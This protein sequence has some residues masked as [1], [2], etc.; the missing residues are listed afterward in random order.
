MNFGNSK[1]HCPAKVF[2]DLFDN[3]SK[4]LNDLSSPSRKDW[5]PTKFCLQLDAMDAEMADAFE[6]SNG[7]RSL[8]TRRLCRAQT[9]LIDGDEQENNSNPTIFDVSKAFCRPGVTPLRTYQAASCLKEGQLREIVQLLIFSH[10]EAAPTILRLLTIMDGLPGNW[11]LAMEFLERL[12]SDNCNLLPTRV[13]SLIANLGGR[14]SFSLCDWSPVIE[15]AF[16]DHETEARWA[17]TT[18]SEHRWKG[19]TESVLR[20]FEWEAE[21]PYALKPSVWREI[22]WASYAR[23][24]CMSGGGTDMST[25]SIASDVM[26]DGDSETKCFESLPSQFGDAAFHYVR[27]GGSLIRRRTTGTGKLMEVQDDTNP[28]SFSEDNDSREQPIVL[29]PS[30]RNAVREIASQLAY[31]VPFILEGPT[32]CGKTAI[33]SYLAQLTSYD[34]NRSSRG[35]HAP[36]VTFIQMDSAMMQGDGESFSSQIGTVVP[37]PEGGGFCWRPGA[38]GAAAERGDWIVLENISGSF[39]RM[40]SAV[41]I[42]RKLANAK[43]GD[44][45]EAPGRGEPITIG[46]GFRL[47]ATRTVSQGG[48]DESWD[49]PGG[50]ETWHRVTM[51]EISHDEK[52]QILSER[53][54]QISDCISRLVD[55]VEKV[56][57]YTE[58]LEGPLFRTPTLREAVRICRRLDSLKRNS[59]ALTIEN[60]FSETM[61]ALV[62]WCSSREHLDELSNIVA[63]GWSLSPTVGL[64][65]YAS[66][67]PRLDKTNGMVKIGR[68]SAQSSAAP[69]FEVSRLSL[70]GYT[71]RLLERTLRCLELG[72]PVLLSGE[73]GSGKT[74]IIQELASLMGKKLVV[75]NLSRQSELDDL[76]G[77]FRPVDA[78]AAVPLLAKRFES[79]FCQCM[80]RQKNA[81]FLDALQ[82]ASRST[83]RHSRALRLMEG[84]VTAI[85]KSSKQQSRTLRQ[86]WESII[87]VLRKLGISVN[88]NDTQMAPETSTTHN[89]GLREPLR[90]RP[91]ISYGMD[92][93]SSTEM[94]KPTRKIDFEFTDG[95][96][97]QAMRE[98]AWI[99]LDELNLGPPELLE[100]L[101]SILEVGRV[102]LAD[103][104]GSEISAQDGFALFGAMNPP[105]DTG[106]RPLPSVLR[107]RFTEIHVGDMLN[108]EDLMDLI[109]HKFIICSSENDSNRLSHAETKIAQDTTNFYLRSY[110]MAKEG[111]IEDSARRPVR[112]SLRSLSRMLDFAYG[113]MGF[114]KV[115]DQ[116]RRRA[117]CEGAI[118]AFGTQLPGK[119]RRQMYELVET[120]I[121]QES[122]R[123]F[124][125]RQLRDLLSVPRNSPVS[126][127][128][129][130]GFPVEWTSFKEGYRLKTEDRFIVTPAVEKTLT[131]VCRA[132]IV[133][134]PKLPILLQGPTAAGKTSLVSYLAEQ[135]GNKLVRINNHEHTELSEYIGR[136]VATEDGSLLFSEGPLVRAARRGYWVMLDE[137]NLA[138][139]DVLESLNRLLDD[140]R[141]VFIPETAEVVK[142]ASGF[143]L[144]ATQNPPGL[145]GGRKELSRAFRSR[146]IEVQVDELPD[147]DL[148]AILERRADIPASFARR[149]VAVMR[150]L[151][152]QRRAS[153]LFS[154]RE[155]YITARDLFRWAARGPRSRDE[156]AIHGFMLLAERAR[157]T[158]ERSVIRA[159]LCKEVGVSKE[160]LTD[161][162]LY[163]L[164]DANDD[165]D[166]ASKQCLDVSLQKLSLDRKSISCALDAR[167]IVLTPS[168]RRMLTLLIHSTANTEPVLLVGATGGGKTSCCAAIASA[169]SQQL[170]TVN[171]HRHT[172]ASDI[173]GGF[174]PVRE[175]ASSTSLFEWVD[176][177]LI[178]AMKEGSW[179]LIDEINMADDAV[180]ERLNP[181]LET[182][183]TILLSEKGANKLS[184]SPDIIIAAEKFR[185]LATMN[186]G[187]DFGKKELS[188]ALRNR[189]TEVWIPPPAC[190]DDYLPIIN[191]RLSCP[192]HR[193]EQWRLTS[194]LV[195]EIIEAS[196]HD[197]HEETGGLK[198]DYPS[199][200]VS[201]RDLSVWCEF[202][203][204]APNVCELDPLL[205]AVHGSRLVFLDGLSV[206]LASNHS[207]KL[208]SEIWNR[209]LDKMPPERRKLAEKARYDEEIRITV[210]HRDDSGQGERLK[211]DRFYI[212]TNKNGNHKLL[213]ECTS[214][215]SFKAP[216]TMRNSAR[217]ARAMC[218]GHRPVL[219]E[220]PPG[221]GKSSLIAALA[222]IS[223]F[224]YSRVNLS[225]GTEMSDLVGCDAPG[226]VQGKFVFRRGPL[227]EALT[228]GGWILLD[229]LNLAS[230]SVLEGLNSVLDHRKTLFVPELNE[231]FKAHPSFRVFGAQ[232][233][234]GDGGGRRGLPKSFLNR[235]TRVRVEAP[236]NEDF[237]LIISSTHPFLPSE[238]VSQLIECLHYLRESPRESVRAKEKFG[239]R[240]ALRWCDL[241]S[242]SYSRSKSSKTEHFSLA[243]L[244]ACF[245]VVI[246][247]G[248][249]ACERDAADICFERTFGQPCE[250]L[251]TTPSVRASHGDGFRIGFVQVKNLNKCRVEKDIG[252]TWVPLLTT[253]SSE[254]QALSFAVNACWPV[255]LFSPSS[256]TARF[257]SRRI[258]EQIA[259]LFGKKLCIFDGA[260]LADAEDFV[261]SYVQ[262]DGIASMRKIVALSEDHM[263]RDMYLYGEEKESGIEGIPPEVF[264]YHAQL[265]KI[266]EE[267][268]GD[269][270]SMRN[271]LPAFLSYADFMI[272]ALRK[273]S[274]IQERSNSLLDELEQLRIDVREFEESVQMANHAPFKWRKSD[275][276]LAI[277]RGEWIFLQDADAC[278]PALLDRLN[279]I[280]ERAAVS[281]EDTGFKGQSMTL[282][283]TILAEAPSNEDGT[284]VYLRPHSHFRMFFSI[285][286]PVHDL[287][288]C[289]LS[290]AL[291]D[292][293][294]KLCVEGCLSD[295]DSSALARLGG[296]PADHQFQC[297]HEDS[298]PCNASQL[299]GTT[300]DKQTVAHRTRLRAAMNEV[301]IT[302]RN[303]TGTD[304]HGLPPVNA[305]DCASEFWHSFSDLPFTSVGEF[306]DNPDLSLMERDLASMRLLESASTE[307]FRGF[308]LEVGRFLDSNT[309]GMR[310]DICKEESRDGLNIEGA[311]RHLL[312]T[313]ANAFLL[314]ST[315]PA[316][317][318]ARALILKE[319]ASLYGT[320]LACRIYSD[321]ASVVIQNPLYSEL[322]AR[323]DR[324]ESQ[325]S[326]YGV[327]IDP[328]FSFDRCSQ[329]L[330]THRGGIDLEHY[331]YIGKQLRTDLLALQTFRNIWR[332]AERG[333]YNENFFGRAKVMFNLER[334]TKS[335]VSGRIPLD[336]IAYDIVQ[337]AEAC[338]DAFCHFIKKSG[339]WEVDREQEWMDFFTLT[340]RLC[341]LMIA[342]EEPARSSLAAVMYSIAITLNNIE[343]RSHSCF[344]GILEDLYQRLQVFS[345]ELEVTMFVSNKNA[346]PYSK[347]G[348]DLET[349]FLKSME[350]VKQGALSVTQMNAVVNG[351]A[352]LTMQDLGESN[353]LP[354]ELRKVAE[355]IKKKTACSFQEGN[356]LDHWSRVVHQRSV[357]MM[358]RAISTITTVDDAQL[359][360]LPARNQAIQIFKACQKTMMCL[361]HVSLSSLVCI[362]KMKWILESFQTTKPESAPMKTS[363]FD[364]LSLVSVCL[365]EEFNSLLRTEH[366]RHSDPARKHLRGVTS[367]SSTLF[368]ATSTTSAPFWTLSEASA[369]A[370]CSASLIAKGNHRVDHTSSFSKAFLKKN[371]DRDGLE[372]SLLA[373]NP[374]VPFDRIRVPGTTDRGSEILG[375]QLAGL[376]ERAVSGDKGVSKAE[377]FFRLGKAWVAVGVT[378][379]NYYHAL[380][381]RCNGID[382]SLFSSSMRSFA[383]HN[384]CLAS[385]SSKVYEIFASHRLGGDRFSG[386][387]PDERL[388]RTT[389][390]YLG[391]LKK[392][393]RNNIFRPPDKNTFE[394]YESFVHK[395][396]SSV[397][398]RIMQTSLLTNFRSTLSPMERARATEEAVHLAETCEALS[399]ELKSEG[400]FGHFRDVSMLLVLGLQ[401]VQ[402]GLHLIRKAFE[403]C[404]P[405]HSSK[406]EL[407]LSFLSDILLFPRAAHKQAAK[408]VESIKVSKNMLVEGGCIT[409]LSAYLLEGESHAAHC[410]SNGPSRVLS[411]IVLEWKKLT[412]QEEKES[413]AKESLHVLRE[414]GRKQMILGAEIAEKL[415]IDE[416]ADYITTFNPASQQEEEDL[417]GLISFEAVHS[418]SILESCNRNDVRKGWARSISPENF[419]ALHKKA[420][421]PTVELYDISARVEERAQ[422][423]SQLSSHLFSLTSDNRSY[424][425]NFPSVWE[426][427][428]AEVVAQSHAASFSQQ[429]NKTRADVHGDSN[430]RTY[431][432]YVDPNIAELT[433]AS[434]VLK[435]LK[436]AVSLLQERFFKDSGNHPVLDEVDFTISRIVKACK[437]ES[438]L[439]RIVL[440]LENVLRKADE[441]HR[442]FA[443]P[444]T[445]LDREIMEV[446]KLVARW[447][448]IE[449]QSWP[450][451]LQSRVI[452][453]GN[454]GCRWVFLLYDAILH[455]GI[456]S[457]DANPDCIKDVVGALDQF[458][459]SSPCGEFEVR[460]DMVFSLGRHILSLGTCKAEN[461]E[462]LGRC[463]LGLSEYYRLFLNGVRRDIDD[464]KSIID[465]ELTEFTKLTS[466]NGSEDLGSSCTMS[467]EKDKYLQYF[468]LKNAAEKTRRKLHKL[469]LKV[470]EV[471]RTPVYESLS[472]QLASIGFSN[473]IGAKSS[474]GMDLSVEKSVSEQVRCACDSLT[475]EMTSLTE[476]TATVDNCFIRKGS[477]LSRVP[478]LERKLVSLRKEAHALGKMKCELATE[479]SIELRSMVRR[480]ID[481]LRNVKSTHIQVKRRALAELFK[482]LYRAGISPF[483]NSLPLESHK[484]LAEPDPTVC[485]EYNKVANDL[486]WKSASQNQRLREVSDS[487]SRNAEIPNEDAGKFRA[488]CQCML[489]QACAQRRSLNEIFGSFRNLSSEVAV[490]NRLRI[491]NNVPCQLHTENLHA[492]ELEKVLARL[493]DISIDLLASEKVFK[494]VLQRTEDTRAKFQGSATDQTSFL[495]K[496]MSNDSIGGLRALES[497]LHSA[498][499]SI[500]EIVTS[501][502]LTSVDGKRASTYG[503][504]DGRYADAYIRAKDAISKFREELDDLC[505]MAKKISP[506]NFVSLLLTPVQSFLHEALSATDSV[507]A[508]AAETEVC[509]ISSVRSQMNR[510]ANTIIE[511]ILIS[512]Q[513]ILAWNDLSITSNG[514]QSKNDNGVC[515]KYTIRDLEERGLMKTAN[516]RV[517]SLSSALKLPEI[518]TMIQRNTDAVR[519]LL[520][521]NLSSENIAEVLQLQKVVARFVGKYL[522]NLA[523]PA[524]LKC[525]Q[526][527]LHSL[528]LLQTLSSVFVG[529]CVDGFC[530]PPEP[531][532]ALAGESETEEGTGGGFGDAGEGDLSSAQNVSDQIEDEEQLL[533]LREQGQN[534][535]DNPE[536]QR[537][538]DRDED[539]VDMTTDF[540]GD[541]QDLKSEDD[542][543]QH[544]D[545]DVEKEMAPESGTGENIIDQRIW[546]DDQKDQSAAESMGQQ[547]NKEDTGPLANDSSDLVA[548]NETS[549][550]EGA[551]DPTRRDQEPAEEN[552]SEAD[553]DLERE[554]NG[555]RSDDGDK[556]MTGPQPAN[557]SENHS[558][559][560]KETDSATEKEIE[561]SPNDRS[562]QEDLPPQHEDG[563]EAQRQ[564]ATRTDADEDNSPNL[565]NTTPEDSSHEQRTDNPMPDLEN[566]DD[567]EENEMVG[568]EQREEHQEV[569]K[570]V[571]EESLM[572]TTDFAEDLNLQ[573][574]RGST[575]QSEEEKDEGSSET[576]EGDSVEQ[577]ADRMHEEGETNKDTNQTTDV[578]DDSDETKNGSIDRRAEKYSATPQQEPFLEGGKGKGMNK[579]GSQKESN[580]YSAQYDRGN[581]TDGFDDRDIKAQAGESNLN[582]LVAGSDLPGFMSGHE[583]D[584]FGELRDGEESNTPDAR[585]NNSQLDCNPL[586]IS[587]PEELVKVWKQHLKVIESE[588]GTDDAMRE[589]QVPSD[590][591]GLWEY[592][593]K[594]DGEDHYN[595][596]HALGPA[597]EDQ[598]KPLN[599]QEEEESLN[600]EMQ[601]GHANDMNGIAEELP[602]AG[603]TNAR[604]NKGN[605]LNDEDSML[606]LDAEDAQRDDATYVKPHPAHKAV[607]G[608]QE[609]MQASSPEEQVPAVDQE[610][611][612]AAEDN[613][614]RKE[615]DA[616]DTPLRRNVKL[617]WTMECLDAM[618]AIE[619]WHKLD[620]KVSAGSAVLCEQLRLVLEP[621][622]ASGLSGGYR[623]GKRLNMR[624]VIEYV[625]SDF[626]KDRI[627]LR[628]VKPDKR[629]YDVLIAIDDSASM[630]ESE[631]GT[632]AVESLAL[633]LSALS[634]LEIGRVGVARFGVDADMVRDFEEP[635]PM[636]A[637]AGGQMLE[638]FSFSQEHT[639]IVKLLQFI[640]SKMGCSAYSGNV[641]HVSLAFVISDGRLS[642]RDEVRRQLRRLKKSNVLIA[643]IILDQA[644]GDQPSIY[645]VKR[646]DYDRKGNLTISP[647]MEDFP[648]EF[649][650]TVRDVRSLPSVLADAL[651]QWVEATNA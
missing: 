457:V 515:E 497:L 258:V 72:E 390:A 399:L 413:E 610:P 554:E 583:G 45:L 10:L 581:D 238:L 156:L 596:M 53:F 176:G 383:R 494:R 98:G 79:A 39:G 14:K 349:D 291:L 369:E 559:A 637:E 211:L 22:Q 197:F 524:V 604:M 37:I 160:L 259:T 19:P 85:P 444:M 443:T 585:N 464:K 424:I 376:V 239:L 302:Q 525:S 441:W 81:A 419:W 648:V 486:F 556:K 398:S 472:R 405:S 298:H 426:T 461:T 147:S 632:M 47:A 309:A 49:P 319:R 650:A 322:L 75:V 574:G 99:L 609:K 178:E 563:P 436:E 67:K 456:Q 379:L 214:A 206:G 207:G 386:S 168:M 73:T 136:Y 123:H 13:F 86:E 300:I 222:S 74:A 493:K 512:S 345:A 35:S 102:T 279:P 509:Q 124:R 143:R 397:V 232:N 315:S 1:W 446:S 83:K 273:S 549:N 267:V 537:D 578:N 416:D 227:L 268:L 491:N 145:Y 50:W 482:T 380:I 420:Y 564:D 438:P 608:S 468:R 387:V 377:S 553:N 526:F 421:P 355:L 149:M 288:Q 477:L 566:G 94:K 187:G 117:L 422:Q 496:N 433:N 201:I 506:D 55:V 562:C 12:T 487:R 561:S 236:G 294:L 381:K 543:E 52:V 164:Y 394:M 3:L 150:E 490:L 558:E 262:H 364:V 60:A 587:Q 287:T 138:P 246:L 412:L 175:K 257:E 42:I 572:E 193:S 358:N 499:T 159:I 621:T 385:L 536:S 191:Q 636:A 241:I 16:K 256:T 325:P 479:F 453:C 331:K 231:E 458:L 589:A 235:F 516:M 63:L 488:F 599:I 265:R 275:F 182:G 428:A 205:A 82:K 23:Y 260:S 8:A 505:L 105:T 230:Q 69:Q 445:R 618:S 336:V 34:Q 173:L 56:A 616:E 339:E 375:A 280:F 132:L 483:E 619:L 471:M 360:S 109:A 2:H 365:L 80:S 454:R 450:L 299:S 640:Y 307:T 293:S 180:V 46:R 38:I 463:L 593:N 460:L 192:L 198:R 133:G 579:D 389:T 243:Q 240:D 607:E 451:L 166:D 218:V 430:Q 276:V 252:S 598:H 367:F 362:Q 484:W 330:T 452:A 495:I 114:L 157:S 41:S 64:D 104:R 634:R 404:Y 190:I 228:K 29:T 165:D 263:F 33:L 208:E 17:L 161:E 70:T 308:A 36:G 651:R 615:E 388:N 435:N 253:R 475:K 647:Y 396:H 112:F 631:A 194:S 248:L 401:E 32:G 544:I 186:P 242:D 77:G 417:Y 629:S 306:V 264:A 393:R 448:R 286:R 212:P 434:V 312:Q 115:G 529:L 181:V 641:E 614:E 24:L 625:A 569:E 570:G 539:G 209:I 6:L 135:T 480:R 125:K 289:G 384:I 410:R 644:I 551:S 649:Y 361:P 392:S 120:S 326:S 179:M 503:L 548:R 283:P 321:R 492:Q 58:K 28:S 408:A 27:V 71:L 48:R 588:R 423:V 639:D 533:G 338:L 485:T 382:P 542:D 110:Q 84:A 185:I 363:F 154:G 101:V 431:N 93:Q 643:F 586:R 210:G 317:L 189:F 521:M 250:A 295:H 169:L 141:E 177:P 76:M 21:L 462:K 229:E 418:D 270:N 635:L 113:L 432:F 540:D 580:E 442:L 163:A 481:E 225:D 233:S 304:Q 591:N 40:S 25:A 277:E 645:D 500:R 119:S 582:S 103:E 541:L 285:S 414:V 59:G 504:A 162:K 439:S 340:G 61:D 44:K 297:A 642:N 202:I 90:K 630:A 134:A 328:L 244:Y 626:Q 508:N 146:F 216:S 597:T 511:T 517:T 378:N 152:L 170:L 343:Q 26:Q 429:R 427:F 409:A 370:A 296:L 527:H 318:S 129:L 329:H 528:R 366:E 611:Y 282:S 237:R 622:E 305:S 354:Q 153:G 223:G 605:K 272:R 151:Q 592:D 623:T 545:E 449:V 348:Q 274:T 602:R 284:P 245:D 148:H 624:R 278:P 184:G 188:P 531:D 466:W 489:E 565:D 314:G 96:L 100:Q 221:C 470:D 372:I 303:H 513:E 474:S 518:L 255:T 313:S 128:L 573:D 351:L 139:S 546:G 600:D 519:R 116:E 523:M 111:L 249:R 15:R 560:D 130:H 406:L 555:E 62:A 324:M 465:K 373:N 557:H 215:F 415:A 633:V 437:V 290:K 646:V 234:A 407:Q 171:C 352:T 20:V 403:V 65:I 550:G 68:A 337:S 224:D 269:Q 217:L 638:R 567:G 196:L 532:K 595:D 459:R 335:A 628:R 57:K 87:R 507:V 144:F 374:L 183:R 97:I 473:S 568:M 203:V 601:A 122:Q 606:D 213:D 121:L 292:R 247:R 155:G 311:K 347:L 346:I 5:T 356:S 266:L 219:L 30:V 478:V 51:K 501:E 195:Q 107:T 4:T 140:N 577:Q 357:Q 332:D 440:G 142:A 617:P 514:L 584:R 402:Y 271:S 126:I 467:K 127:R 520:K 301:S 522:D 535:N 106:K 226:I 613:G 251:R 498:G 534:N 333:A 261:G 538:D 353:G 341:E 447:R 603:D 334:A 95:I 66:H 547:M 502:T 371:A 92:N 344:Q 54:V 510:D 576:V 167:S 368:M 88:R 590:T 395:V 91:R 281:F 612:A 89:E 172:E 137:L 391:H 571:N 31:G 552:H 320:S 43:P 316:N 327:S 575:E 174:R 7:S 350:S 411:E 118:T 199:L 476:H 400:S 469:C 594:N 204:N 359:L 425:D 18:L 620:S 131:D 310:T 108:E 78:D 158:K 254:L 11:E 342:D 220:G 200:Q 455:E 627:W 530:R 9:T 323:R